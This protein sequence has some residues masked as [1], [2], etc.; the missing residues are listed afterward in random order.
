MGI[1]FREL[2]ILVFILAVVL[3]LY[4]V[5]FLIA[6]SKKHPQKTAILILNLLLGWTMLGWVVAL[7]W[8]CMN[9]TA[10]ESGQ[11]ATSAAAAERKCP[12]CAERIKL[13]AK[14]G[15]KLAYCPTCERWAVLRLSP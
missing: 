9:T 11:A 1:G 3:P 10:R 4:L 14:H 7:V 8:A 6:R 12:H 13:A 2:F 5:P 15:H